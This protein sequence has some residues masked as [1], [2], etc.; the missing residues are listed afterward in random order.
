MKLY[1]K[2][3]RKKTVLEFILSFYSA[4]EGCNGLKAHATYFDKE[5]TEKHCNSY[6]WRSFDD[7]FSVVNTEYPSITEKKLMHYLVI[8]NSEKYK[9]HFGT[10]CAAGITRVMPYIKGCGFQVEN[11]AKGLKS[12]YSVRELFELLN[13]KTNKEYLEYRKKHIK[14][15]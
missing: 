12:K 1:T 6:K 10:C 13:I 7:I 2:L 4:Y 11:D 5:C 8:Y 3:T 14:T 15:E 9:M